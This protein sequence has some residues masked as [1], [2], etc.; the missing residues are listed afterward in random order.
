VAFD[1]KKREQDIMIKQYAANKHR[2]TYLRPRYL[3]IFEYRVGL[4]DGSFHTLREAGE[5][6][7]VKWVRIQQITARVEYELE[8]LQGRTRDRGA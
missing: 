1:M 8:Q 5:K 6:Y 7:G 2:L 4:V 3:E